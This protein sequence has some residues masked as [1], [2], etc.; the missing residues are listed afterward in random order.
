MSS[1]RASYTCM[2]AIPKFA[3]DMSLKPPIRYL[4]VACKSK[5]GLL[6][7][8]DACHVHTQVHALTNAARLAGP[9]LRSIRHAGPADHGACRACATAAWG[10][11]WLPFIV[12]P[13]ARVLNLKI[14]FGSLCCAMNSMEC[15]HP[16]CSAQS[17][18]PF[19]GQS[20]RFRGS[21]A[22]AKA[23]PHL[24]PSCCRSP[25]QHLVRAFLLNNLPAEQPSC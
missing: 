24:S 22:A 11:A 13:I 19:T 6:H 15:A 9:W 8:H 16:R 3:F 18:S 25:R 12:K 21:A 14:S 10:D 17:G 7:E 23:A 2:L 5:A 4:N 1:L 20:E